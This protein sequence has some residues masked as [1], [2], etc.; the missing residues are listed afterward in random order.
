MGV[1]GAT[2][3][4][5]CCIRLDSTLK[6]KIDGFNDAAFRPSLQNAVCRLRLFKVR[7]AEKS[8][9]RAGDKIRPTFY[10]GPFLLSS[11]SWRQRIR[12]SIL[13]DRPVFCSWLSPGHQTS[14]KSFFCP[15]DAAFVLKQITRSHLPIFTSLYELSIDWI[16]VLFCLIRMPS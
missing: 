5:W 12:A 11:T 7:T 14:A 3:D 6:W 13:I 8:H 2:S 15:L 16:V 9:S 10:F 4:L 1:T